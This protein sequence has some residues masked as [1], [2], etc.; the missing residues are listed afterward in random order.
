MTNRT[1][2]KNFITDLEARFPVNSWLADEIHLWPMIR[3]ELYFHLIA[4]IEGRQAKS[5]SAQPGLVRASFLSKL[6]TSIKRKF[7]NAGIIFE[8]F[9]WLWQLPKKKICFCGCRCTS[10]ES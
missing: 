10:R 6:K 1:D 4:E 5:V 2:I 9:W 3:L 8:Y 7:I